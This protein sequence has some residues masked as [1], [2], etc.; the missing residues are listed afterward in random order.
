MIPD[1][2]VRRAARKASVEPRVVELDYVLGWALWGLGRSETLRERLLFKGGTCLRKCYI[3]DY[4]FSEDLDFTALSWLNRDGF[5]EEIAAAMERASDESGIDFHVREPRFE[6]VNDEYGKE[7]LQI[8]IYWYGPHTLR[9]DPRAIRLDIS[10]GEAVVFDPVE[11][12]ASHPYSDAPA[13]GEIRCPC[14]ALGR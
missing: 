9:G 3:P 11:R 4:R 6:V 7:S 5:R 10:R 8:R 12:V 1:A 13:V 2:E 14:Y